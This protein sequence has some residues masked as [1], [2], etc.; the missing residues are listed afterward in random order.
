[1]HLLHPRHHQSSPSRGNRRRTANGG[2]AP[3][4]PPP[5]E[6][7]MV[8][9]AQPARRLHHA[10]DGAWRTSIMCARITWRSRSNASIRC[11]R[12]T[13][14]RD[15]TCQRRLI[16]RPRRASCPRSRAPVIGRPRRTRSPPLHRVSR[17]AGDQPRSRAASVSCRSPQN[18]AR[19]LTARTAASSRPLS[20]PPRRS[21]RQLDPSAG[22]LPSSAVQLQKAR[23]SWWRLTTTPVAGANARSL[24]GQASRERDPT[25][26]LGPRRWNAPDE[27]VFARCPAP[28]CCSPIPKPQPP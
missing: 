8:G 5:A 15:L 1:M 4:R 12:E 18:T 9:R 27:R 21:T 26:D 10:V 22:T 25:S 20:V 16:G 14:H 3:S 2:A 11:G 17:T 24:L 23:L 6:A 7:R 28:L 19:P 13:R